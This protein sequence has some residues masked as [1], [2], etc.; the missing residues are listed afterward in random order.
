MSTPT[1]KEQFVNQLD[2]QEHRWF[3][4]YTRFKSE[5]SAQKLLARKGINAYCPL[6]RIVRRYNRSIRQVEK[7]LISCYIF[8]KIKKAEYVEVLETENVVGFVKFSRNLIAIPEVEIDLLRRITLEEGLELEAVKGALE[9]G[10]PVEITAG[11]LFGMKGKIV[12]SDGKN[13]FQVELETLGY[14]LLITIDAAFL[15]KENRIEKLIVKD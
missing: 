1:Q 10:D 8:V 15:E 2:E 11:N 7:P 12:K 5:K 13:K 14:S 6:Q 4:V 3:A 9:E